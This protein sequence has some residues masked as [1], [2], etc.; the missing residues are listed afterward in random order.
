MQLNKPIT[1]A[2][3]FAS[4]S[5]VACTDYEGADRPQVNTEPSALSRAD[6]PQSERMDALE[7]DTPVMAHAEYDTVEFMEASSQLTPESKTRLDEL[8]ET[9]DQGPILLT[10]RMRNGDAI[11]ATPPTEQ[12]KTLT[13]ERVTAVKNYLQQSGVAIEQVKVDEAGR[14][15]DKGE[16]APM[17]RETEDTGADA[18][19]VVI[20]IATT[21]T[22]APSDVIQR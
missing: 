22:Q 7:G 6:Y 8:A 9:L 3:I 15:A 5:M 4:L 2:I 11:D 1:T 21:E 17:A 18:Q 16:D 19:H 20:T 13:P 14:V 10:L 12:F